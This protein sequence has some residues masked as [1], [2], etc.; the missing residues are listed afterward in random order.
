M[1]SLDEAIAAMKADP[2]FRALP[3]ARQRALI[4]AKHGEAQRLAA[5]VASAGMKGNEAQ[6]GGW[7]KAANM[8]GSAALGAADTLTAGYAAPLASLVGRGMNAAFPG[9]P[10]LPPQSSAEIQGGMDAA[11]ADYPTSNV[12]G[13]VGGALVGP[14]AR[15][16]G[17]AGSGVGAL[18][19]FATNEATG[20]VGPQ[21]GAQFSKRL[22]AN[23]IGNAAGAGTANFTYEAMK[24]QSG[25]LAER[26]GNAYYSTKEMAK[27]PISWGLLGATSLAQ[28]AGEAAFR[29]RP[30]AAENASAFDEY[31]RLTGKRVPLEV[32]SGSADLQ[33]TFKEW[34][35]I[36]K[37]KDRIDTQRKEVVEG[38]AD[39]LKQYRARAKIAPGSTAELEAPAAANVRRLLTGANDVS[40]QAA[41][42][43]TRAT[44][45]MGG[46]VPPLT[47]KRL[48][49]QKPT[50]TTEGRPGVLRTLSDAVDSILSKRNRFDR[51]DIDPILSEIKAMAR[52]PNTSMT[53]SE[54]ETL[55]ERLRSTGKF[56]GTT[57]EAGTVT[58]AE[59][60]ELYHAIS[61][62]AAQFAPDY[63]NVTKISAQMHQA[64][65]AL[66]E[67]PVTMM[68]RGML[69]GLFSRGRDFPRAWSALIE[70]SPPELVAQT[71]GWYFQQLIDTA[72]TSKGAFTEERLNKLL[73]SNR[74]IFSEQ[75]AKMVLGPELLAD[76][77][78]A[79]R[80]SSAING[81]G[82][83]A[84]GSSGNSAS[85]VMSL[86]TNP[87][88]F[89][90]RA[91]GPFGARAAI[92][93]AMGGIVE[94]QAGRVRA[95]MLEEQAQ[96]LQTVG[97]TMMGRRAIGTNQL[98]STLGNPFSQ[99]P[100]QPGEVP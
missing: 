66:A 34:A 69:V 44:G 18:A 90:A 31:E 25:G 51:S 99:Q 80:V 68:D 50:I 40:A 87:Y 61:E 7:G 72:T 100:P 2:D 85:V 8:V 57:K 21:I 27:N 23:L 35:G 9:N 29:L 20:V 28:S 36:G 41:N 93:S 65:N 42:A 70:H 98:L 58:N 79:A 54:L 32:R 64:E 11:S 88:M 62:A 71:K 37:M 33:E 5:S 73:G 26:L 59:T 19:K 63:A 89:V 83:F 10:M 94:K 38:I 16:L 4:L 12:L 91:L 60:G 92:R 78:R 74:Q 6:F 86:V 46:A 14:V 56:A 55:R 13:K 47:A 97:P 3:P 39:T 82:R 76:I 53:T 84:A 67:Y 81:N 48:A 45:A 49:L 22:L 77:R 43:E 24:N 52:D 1:P 15:G 95:G 96:Q 30:Q 75:Q 17:A